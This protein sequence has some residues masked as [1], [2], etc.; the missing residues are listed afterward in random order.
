[1]AEVFV[2]D[3]HALVWHLFNPVRLGPKATD[4]FDRLVVAEAQSLNARL[5]TV[6]SEIADANIVSVVW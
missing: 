5:I 3:T 4:I 2:T 1:M 6:D